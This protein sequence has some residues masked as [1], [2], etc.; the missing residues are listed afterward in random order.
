MWSQFSAVLRTWH[1]NGSRRTR[2]QIRAGDR[3]HAALFQ[4]R[5]SSAKDVLLDREENLGAT[6]GVASDVQPFI[7]TIIPGTNKGQDIYLVM[8]L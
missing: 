8:L 6:L 2:Y 3:L 1:S 7:D 5:S 4:R